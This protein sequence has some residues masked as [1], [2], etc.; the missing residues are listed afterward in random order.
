MKTTCVSQ[1]VGVSVLLLSGLTAVF[2]NVSPNRAQFLTGETVSLSCEGVQSSAEWTLKR[3]D[4]GK[5]E[6]CGRD[7][8]DFG[9]FNGS[10]CIISK[11]SPR[12]DS[13]LYWC[14]DRAGQKSPEL[15]I[16][17][18]DHV[19]LEIPALPVM[20]GSDVT[21]RCRARSKSYSLNSIS[22][23]RVFGIKREVDNLPSTLT[24][25]NAQWSDE[26]VYSCTATEIDMMMISGKSRLV[27]RAPPTGKKAVIPMEKTPAIDEEYDDP[28]DVDVISEPDLTAA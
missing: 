18:S 19:I 1:L 6:T 15:K 10:S 3:K 16:F 14:E 2:V 26:G 28:G 9:L 20:S 7:Q 22:R 8:Q 4:Y 24:I 21:L 27:V 11:L 23:E 12:S 25:Y 13:R 5:N 17:V